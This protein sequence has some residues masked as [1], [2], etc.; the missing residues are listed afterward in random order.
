MVP[1]KLVRTQVLQ[2]LLPLYC[3]I[4]LIEGRL[5]KQ[6]TRKVVLSKEERERILRAGSSLCDAAIA[7]LLSNP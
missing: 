5:D 1:F 6:A 2:D 3:L 7:L 4:D